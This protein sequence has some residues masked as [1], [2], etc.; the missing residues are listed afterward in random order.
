VKKKAFLSALKVNL[1]FEG[2]NFTSLVARDNNLS[3][4]DALKPKERITSMICLLP[5]VVS[6]AFFGV[7]RVTRIFMVDL[8]G[9][10]SV[11]NI[12][13]NKYINHGEAAFKEAVLSS[14]E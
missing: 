1:V 4:L 3:L 14:S 13:S 7:F 2:Q 8:V 11:A 10:S 5:Y 9:F 6:F 12:D